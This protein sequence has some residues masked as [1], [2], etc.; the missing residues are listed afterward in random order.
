MG[1]K[2]LDTKKN[3]LEASILDVWK[4]AAK[5][6]E[7][8]T[9]LGEKKRVRGWGEGGSAVFQGRTMA[10]LFLFFTLNEG[11]KMRSNIVLKKCF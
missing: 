10:D 2:Y 6:N 11:P 3:T 8:K 5:L 4:E 9:K 1:K 7:Y